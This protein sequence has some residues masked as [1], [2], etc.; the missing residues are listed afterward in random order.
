MLNM[1]LGSLFALVI[2][3][4]QISYAHGSILAAD[5]N[6]LPKYVFVGEIHGTK[7]TPEFFLEVVSEYART[8]KHCIIGLEIPSSEEKAINDYLFADDSEVAN[9]ESIMLSSMFWHVP[10]STYDGRASKAMLDMIKGL[11]K[12]VIDEKR[13]RLILIGFHSK[14]DK[15]AARYIKEVLSKQDDAYFIGLSGNIHARNK[16]LSHPLSQEPMPQF[17]PQSE[18][19]AINVVAGEGNAWNCSS[20]STCGVIS[21][22]PMDNFP[23]DCEDR[24]LRMTPQDRAFDAIFAIRKVTASL[25][26]IAK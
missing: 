2:L 15:D 24:C 20:L 9:K 14:S 8:G 23:T 1:L 26:A 4:P 22:I 16:P 6:P 18:R 10:A 25:Q 19:L 13:N 7:E 11:R 17:F 5:I 3:I 21:L 12:L